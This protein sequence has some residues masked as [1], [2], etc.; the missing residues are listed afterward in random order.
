MGKIPSV[1]WP[2]EGR[3]KIPSKAGDPGTAAPALPKGIVDEMRRGIW[4]DDS[5]TPVRNRV[6]RSTAICPRAQRRTCRSNATAS[7]ISRFDR[8]CQSLA[9]QAM[10][11]QPPEKNAAVG[12]GSP[13]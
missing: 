7:A 3:C 5:S 1:D 10:L 8:S 13:R 11:N 9:G 12:S 4:P 6:S 2:S